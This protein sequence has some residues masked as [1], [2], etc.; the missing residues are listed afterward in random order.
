MDFTKITDKEHKLIMIHVEL[1][2]AINILTHKDEMSL[3][4]LEK[5]ERYKSELEKEALELSLLVE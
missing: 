4:D 5:W 3:K 1:L 2:A